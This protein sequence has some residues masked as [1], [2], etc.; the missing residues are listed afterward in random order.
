MISMSA[1]T[2]TNARKMLHAAIRWGDTLVVV[3][4]VILAMATQT[5][6]TLM[7]AALAHTAAPTTLGVL[8]PMADLTANATGVTLV[9]ARNAT[10]S[11]NALR[12]STIVTMLRPATT[13]W[14]LSNASVMPVTKAVAGLAMILVSVV[15][16]RTRA[17]LRPTV[18]TALVPFRVSAI[19]G[20]PATGMSV[21]R[22]MSARQGLTI[23]TTM[24]TATTSLGAF[25]V[26][27]KMVMMVMVCIARITMSA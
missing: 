16:A 23:A 7:S 1:Q 25:S 2:A 11:M 8:T 20:G 13:L 21:R 3:T 19:A 27:A 5:A 12:L 4:P 26:C 15:I 22:S 6:Q 17:T 24:P 18:S 14:D 10:I 9:T